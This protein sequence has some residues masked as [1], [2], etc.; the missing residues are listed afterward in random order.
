MTRADASSITDPQLDQLH[1]ELDEKTEQLRFL[2]ANTL[3]ELRRNV[4][5]EQASKARWRER[6]EQAEAKLADIRALADQ[7]E[8][9]A[10]STDGGLCDGWW[11]AS[12]RIRT[13][14]DGQP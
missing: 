7:L 9:D 8:A 6:A 2:H 4:E 11:D 5:H 12:D 14:L 3:P 13:V 1:A 10:S